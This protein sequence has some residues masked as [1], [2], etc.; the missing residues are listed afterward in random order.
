MK[1][2]WSTSVADHVLALTWVGDELLITPTTGDLSLGAGPDSLRRLRG[3]ALG[4]GIPAVSQGRIVTCTWDGEVGIIDGGS[5]S[6]RLGAGVI[7]RVKARPDHAQFATT[8]GRSLF[9]CSFDGAVQREIHDDAVVAD[10]AWNPAKPIEIATVG[11]GGAR[12]WRLGM[13]EAFARFDWG[14][15]SVRALWSPDGRWLVTGDQTA[16]VHLY[17]FRRD[18][19]LHIQGYETK[20]RAMDFSPAGDRLATGGG[21]LVTV[22]NVTG[23]TGPENT[24]PVQLRFH[25]ADVEVLAYAPDGSLLA[26][27][28]LDGR[29]IVSNG[30]G[31]PVAAF[32]AEAEISALAWHADSARLAVGS[33][34]GEVTVFARS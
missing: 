11:A 27:G 9:V 3:S 8:L 2:S 4:N 24:T 12:M 25:K 23:K 15:A 1:P 33:A 17:D 16:S 20:V 18:H 28:D 13:R 22:W 34:D 32:D 31:K 19:P 14:G 29:M 7:E 6:V 30:A 10:F 5:A 26:T 21:T